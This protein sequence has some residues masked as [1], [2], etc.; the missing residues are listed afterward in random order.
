MNG[1]SDAGDG[2]KAVVDAYKA[3]CNSGEIAGP[4]GGGRGVYPVSRF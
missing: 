3:R 2:G 4:G 1:C